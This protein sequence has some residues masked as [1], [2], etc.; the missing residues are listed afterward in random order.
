M[1]FLKKRAFKTPFFNIF[2]G[3][4]VVIYFD[5]AATSG[6]KP[7]GVVNAVKYALENYSANPGRSG[8]TL[9]V[10]VAEKILGKE[11]I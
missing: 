11:E 5:N 9:S 3:G 4:I 6:V 2:K 1:E 10:K 8:H 7:Q